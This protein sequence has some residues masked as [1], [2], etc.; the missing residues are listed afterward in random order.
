MPMEKLNW[1]LSTILARIWGTS[2]CF[3]VFLLRTRVGKIYKRRL[4]GLGGDI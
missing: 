4:A 3:I 1:S 2:Y